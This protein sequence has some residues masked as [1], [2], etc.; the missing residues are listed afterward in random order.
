MKAQ[1]WATVREVVEEFGLSC[2]P[3]DLDAVRDALR[4]QLKE[5]HPD[6]TGGEFADGADEARYHCLSDAMQFVDGVRQTSTS[7]VKA[8][9]L[10]AIVRDFRQSLIQVEA[11]REAQEQ[12][13][14][15]CEVSRELGSHYRLFRITSGAFAACGAAMLAFLLKVKDYP[16][17]GPFFQHPVPRAM[18]V[19]A[20]VL[21]GLL[22]VWTWFRERQEK[23]W[24]ERLISDEGLADVFATVCR[25]SRY[26]AYLAKPDEGAVQFSRRYY[27]RAVRSLS[28]YGSGVWHFDLDLRTAERIAKLH[29]KQLMGRGAIREIETPGI[30]PWYEVRESV[31]SQM[32]RTISPSYF[33]EPAY[34]ESLFQRLKVSI[35]RKLMQWRQRS[36]RSEGGGGRD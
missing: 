2:S 32:E 18:T 34:R 4:D 3:E 26:E 8:S 22:F 15:T 16:L 29:L 24:V 23:G 28:R 17:L 5:L 7:I 19:T 9:E 14:I 30:D 6:K 31:V 11:T 33:P 25:Y 12:T 27:T 1:K 35:V 20:V 10:S 21:A 13:E 36:R